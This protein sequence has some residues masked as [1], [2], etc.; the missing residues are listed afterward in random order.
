MKTHSSILN[1]LQVKNFTEAHLNL[2]KNNQLINWEQTF[3][4]LFVEV[5]GAPAIKFDCFELMPH[6]MFDIQH[7]KHRT[8]NRTRKAKFEAIKQNIERNGWKLKYPPIAVFIWPDGTIEIITGN[9]RTEILRSSPFE[10]ENAI[11][12]VYKAVDGY[13]VDQIKDSLDVAGSSFNSIHDPAETVSPEDVF[14]AVSRAIKRYENT[15]GKAGIPCT[16]DAIT[17]RVDFCCGEGVFQPATR[18]QL[19]Y[20]IW[21]NNQDED[22]IISWSNAKHKDYNIN[23]FM[24]DIKYVDNDKVK[25]MVSATESPHNAFTK[26]QHLAVVN[27]K[28]EIRIVLHTG[29]LSGNSLLNS[30]ED[31][32]INFVDKYNSVRRDVCIHL[33]KKEVPDYDRVK[34]WGVLPALGEHHNVSKPVIYNSRTQT[35]YQ[36]DENGYEFD[37]YEEFDKA[38]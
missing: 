32:C 11:V 22:T 33:F 17:E 35:F 27:P 31:R 20:E 3:P 2:V 16:V 34:I 37:V 24:K 1:L 23:K 29:T 6:A 4:E 14:H 8:G 18:L 9:S 19:T 13:T 38:A 30:Y 10:T 7:N 12:A 21:N 5:P 36:D 25:W 26:A 28:C 15:N